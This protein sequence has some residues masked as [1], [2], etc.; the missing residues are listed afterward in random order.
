MHCE[1][2]G[3]A[4]YSILKTHSMEYTAV[5]LRLVR[6]YLYDKSQTFLPCNWMIN[7]LKINE[8]EHGI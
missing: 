6:D 4:V 8:R 1:T 5:Y 7:S 3:K 2:K